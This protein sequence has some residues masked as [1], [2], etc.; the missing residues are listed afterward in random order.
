MSITLPLHVKSSGT[1]TIGWGTSAD[2]QYGI[3]QSE[4]T[5]PQGM[6]KQVKDHI[7]KVVVKLLYDTATTKR[8]SILLDSTKTAPT[9][10]DVVTWATIKYLVMAAP[11]TARNEDFTQLELTLET[12]PGITLA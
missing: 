7:G 11:V 12:C 4:T 5:D 3:V 1:A 10:G 9:I 6:W 2:V 8:I